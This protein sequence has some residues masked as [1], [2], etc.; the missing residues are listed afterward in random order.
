M[1]AA[2]V[3]E[4][5]VANLPIHYLDA[6]S[7][8]KI[9]QIR[10]QLLKAQ[11]RGM[12]V[13]RFESG[14]PSFAV[15][16]PVLDAVDAAARA[17]KT[18]YIPNNGIPQ[19]RDALATKVRDRNG[20]AGI[21]AEDIFVTN[22]AM[23][24]LFVTF[25]A[26]LVPGD[27]VIVPDPM[28]TEV[29]ENVRMAGGVAVGV[30]LSA[31]DDFEYRSDRIEA[32]ITP[33]TRAIFLNT[34]HNP[35]GAVLSRDRLLEILELARA[36]NLWIVSDEAYEDVLYEPWTHTS[37]GSLA[38][39]YADRVISIYSFSKTHAMSGLRVGYI[40]TQSELLRDR[41]PKLLRCTINGVNSLAQWAA[42]AA[43]QGPAD[44]LRAMCAEYAVRR[45]I[46]LGALR[47]LPGISVFAPRGAFY[48]WVELDSSAY[49]RLGVVDAAALSDKLAAAG[50][51]SAPGDAFGDTCTN[52]MRFA[53]SC[54]TA[55][56]REGSVLLRAALGDGIA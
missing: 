15:A 37:I 6:I 21:T 8:G 40:V 28:W 4:P 20:L 39:D 5:T 27:E 29:V 3:A 9:V 56:V 46:M 11:A 50:I 7:L 42:L 45:E 14:D 16:Q 24:A 44:H 47:H 17:G 43:V 25:G 31:E 34:P 35:T 53:F 38:G 49:E 13:F 52:A 55:M 41:I 33:R 54:D 30:E 48:A 36:N 12:R 23:H 22:G 10:E 18:H 19:L 51:G 32:A 2:D 1:P 26:L